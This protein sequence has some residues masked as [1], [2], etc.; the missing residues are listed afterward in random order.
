MG[1]TNLF[2]ILVH[3]DDIIY[4]FAN[5]E[6]APNLETPE[7]KEI[8]HPIIKNILQLIIIKENNS[9]KCYTFYLFIMLDDKFERLYRRKWFNTGQTLLRKPM[10]QFSYISKSKCLGKGSRPNLKD[11]KKLISKSKKP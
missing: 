8:Y 10:L 7:D 1:H 6:L 9:F 4:L 3:G 5:S 2:L 11:L